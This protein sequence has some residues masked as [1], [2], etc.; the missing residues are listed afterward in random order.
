MATVVCSQCGESFTEGWVTF[1][2]RDDI[3]ICYG[4]LDYLNQQRA[5]QLSLRKGLQPLEGFDPVFS[6][7]DLSSAISHYER[8]GFTS[9]R[10]DHGYAFVSWSNLTIH[11]T[12]TE[13]DEAA[14]PS[15][16]YVHVADADHVAERWREAGMEVEGPANQDYGKR[17]GRHIDVD[18]NIIRFGGPPR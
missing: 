7:R 3:A 8:L 12:E 15:Q 11:L 9:S 18:G 13:H 10:H 4:C 1:W 14:K 5:R 6:V 16:L 2:S 17:E